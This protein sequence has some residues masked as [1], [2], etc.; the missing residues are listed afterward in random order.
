MLLSAPPLEH[1]P[2]RNTLCVIWT[3][4][5][6]YWLSARIAAP[7]RSGPWLS[8]RL[9]VNVL[10]ITL[11][12]PPRSKIAPPPPPS[13]RWPAELPS[14]KVRFSTVS[15]GRAW[16]W[17]CEVV[18]CW[19]GSQVSMYRIRRAP[20]PLSVTLP[21]PSRVTNALRLSTRAVACM[22]MVT[23]AGPQLKVMS[24]PFATARTTALEVQLAAVPPPTTRA[25]WAA[26][27]G[28]ACRAVLA[29]SEMASGAP[30]LAAQA[31]A[32]STGAR[33]A[34]R[35]A[36]ERRLGMGPHASDVITACH[37]D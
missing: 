14:A 31:G 27:G 10:L 22:V 20:P 23:G 4:R 13:I 12:W 18:Q 37:G 33:A 11:S 9:P 29:A 8:H 1:R 30:V 16:F 7:P 3:A 6:W 24:P 36:A 17:Q 32:A 34:T 25:G 21:P 2:P 15:L 26:R 35:M 5:P 28:A 19:C